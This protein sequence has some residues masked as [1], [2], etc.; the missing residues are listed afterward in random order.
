MRMTVPEARR[1]ICGHNHLLIL[2][3]RLAEDAWKLPGR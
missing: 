1:F 2:E 3:G